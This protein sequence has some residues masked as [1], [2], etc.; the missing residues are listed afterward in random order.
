MLLLFTCTADGTGLTASPSLGSSFW[1]SCN[2]SGTV[3]P[4][5]KITNSLPNQVLPPAWCPFPPSFKEWV[6]FPSSPSNSQ[7]FPL[8]HTISDFYGDTTHNSKRSPYHLG[9]LLPPN[10]ISL[11]FRCD[12]SEIWTSIQSTIQ[13]CPG[14]CV[15]LCFLQWFKEHSSSFFIALVFH[16]TLPQITIIYT[17]QFTVCMRCPVATSEMVYNIINHRATLA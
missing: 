8:Y 5:A 13:S 1:R 9:P 14:T 10:V 7:C 2:E 15:E 12:I 17:T 6:L 3:M 11:S 16:S 4:E